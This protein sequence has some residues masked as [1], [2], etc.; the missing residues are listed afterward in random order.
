MP[1]VI[2]AVLAS[3]AVFAVTNL[4]DL[5][6]LAVLFRMAARG[7]PPSS[8]QVVAGQ[9]LGIGTL[10]A[11]SALAAAGLV[12]VDE[13]VVGLL[14]LVPLGLGVRG[15]W[16]AG[17]DDEEQD[18][19]VVRG[20]RGVALLTCANGADNVGVYLPWFRQQG[21]E[22]TATFVAVAA[23]LVGLWCVVGVWL[24]GRRP[25]EALLDRWG[26]WL[27]PVLFVVLGVV[28]LVEA[29]TVGILGG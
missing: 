29:G 28:I 14:G 20:V 10:V 13:R 24:A 1:D 9:Y 7:G 3:V 4:D 23:V 5:V 19:V 25:V 27:V 15:L 18:P 21:V 8:S 6:V 12:A 22:G 17:R 26:R 11:V 16:Q 2:A